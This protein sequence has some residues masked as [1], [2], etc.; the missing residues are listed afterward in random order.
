[1]GEQKVAAQKTVLDTRILTELKGHITS[2]DHYRLRDGLIKI[3]DKDRSK[4]AMGLWDFARGQCKNLSTGQAMN[5]MGTLVGY[6]AIDSLKNQPDKLVLFTPQE[7]A[8]LKQSEFKPTMIND[9]I[10]YEYYNR[11]NGDKEQQKQLLTN[12]EQAVAVLWQTAVNDEHNL[13]DII[14]M[15]GPKNDMI[16]KGLKDRSKLIAYSKPEVTKNGSTS[17]E[18]NEL[19]EASENSMKMFWIASIHHANAVYFNASA[20]K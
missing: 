17:K 14:D 2:G 5:V 18:I 10:I 8:F 1:M 19:E 9:R 20:A 16:I 11:L 13:G 3:D 4:Y 12:P 6:G 7:N 15:V